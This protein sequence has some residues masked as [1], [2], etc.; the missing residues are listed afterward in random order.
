MPKTV[1]ISREGISAPPRKA[2][3]I[4]PPDAILRIP[5]VVALHGTTAASALALCGSAALDRRGLEEAAQS[6]GGFPDRLHFYVSS[7]CGFDFAKGWDRRVRISEVRKSIIGATQAVYWYSRFSLKGWLEKGEGEIGGRP[8]GLGVAVFELAPEACGRLKDD[9]TIEL[10]GDPVRGPFPRYLE[11]SDFGTQGV[12]P[13]GAVVTDAE[14]SS[15]VGR[16]EHYQLIEGMDDY[17]KRLLA[18]AAKPQWEQEI[19]RDRG[20]E[21]LR[22][23]GAALTEGIARMLAGRG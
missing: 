7:G 5:K 11:A 9:T 1:E 14:L 2:H 20:Y 22:G 18:E 21:M 6:L 10:K 13:I 3:E 16:L 19:V 12:T 8:R 4:L 15:S 17:E 23:I